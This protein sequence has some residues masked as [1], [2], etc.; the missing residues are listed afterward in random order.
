MAHHANKEHRGGKD[1]QSTWARPNVCEIRADTLG[2]QLHDDAVLRVSRALAKDVRWAVV[3]HPTG[4]M[5]REKVSTGRSLRTRPTG[6]PPWVLQPP[7]FL[8]S[9]AGYD[10]FV[11]V[12]YTG[13]S[14]N[15][16]LKRVSPVEVWR[17]CQADSQQSDGTGYDM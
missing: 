8:V 4:G 10:D 3:D 13:L 2:R 15:Q 16:G 6:S 14:S 1:G 11:H 12:A 17:C 5:Q 7:G 9:A